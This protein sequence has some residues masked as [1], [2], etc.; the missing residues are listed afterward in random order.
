MHIVCATFRKQTRLDFKWHMWQLMVP[1]HHRPY[2]ILWRHILYFNSIFL[3]YQF[4]HCYQR[5][6]E[7]VS[8]RFLAK[9]K[10]TTI[11][12]IQTW[13]ILKI[14]PDENENGKNAYLV[15]VLSVFFLSLC[16]S[17][18]AT[19]VHMILSTSNLAKWPYFITENFIFIFAVHILTVATVYCRSSWNCFAFVNIIKFPKTTQFIYTNITRA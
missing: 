16:V 13:R 17:L 18:Y 5:E 8:E 14:Q 15:N 10:T 11:W 7:R 2:I 3:P 9:Y 12:Q 6:R 1:I 4:P 19:V